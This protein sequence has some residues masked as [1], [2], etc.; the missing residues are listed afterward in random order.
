[1]FFICTAAAEASIEFA[2]EDSLTHY[3]NESGSIQETINAASPGDTIIVESGTYYENVDVNKTG[4]ILQGMDTDSGLPVVNGTGGDFC[5]KLSEDTCTL[6]GF[7][8]T[9]ADEVGVWVASSGNT[10]SDNIVCSETYGFYVD[11]SGYDFFEGYD[12]GLE[13][14][15]SDNTFTDNKVYNN[16][17]SDYD[18]YGIFLYK[19]GFNEFTGN[20]VSNDGNSD[21]D[22]Y[23]IYLYDD[24]N[25][26]VFT[27]NTLSNAGDSDEDCYGIYLYED[28]DS[29]VFT[30][31][32]VSNDGNSDAE[33]CGIYLD[34]Y[35][36]SN[37]FTGNMVSNYGNSDYD[38]YG[39]YLYYEC[40]SNVFT[41]NTLSND[42]DY[43]A[44]CCGIYLDDY[45]NS[46]KFTGN[47]V[48]N[49]GNSDYDCYGIYLYYEC[50]SNVFTD[51]TLSNDGD[52]DAE[53]CGIYLDDYCNSNEFT[54]NT[55]I[56]NGNSDSYCYGIILYDYCE[57]NTFSGNVICG[58]LTLPVYGGDSDNSWCISDQYCL[59]EA[60]YQ[61][62][63][64]T[65]E[66]LDWSNSNDDYCSESVSIGFDFTLDGMTYTRMEVVSNGVIH[67][68]PEGGVELDD[69]DYDYASQWAD[70]YPEETFIFALSDD[71]YAGD[72]GWY[73]YKSYLTGDTD[74]GGIAIPCN[75]TVID[76]HVSTY[77]DYGYSEYPNDFQ[78]VLYEDGTLRFNF[79]R[80]D[81]LSFDYSLDSGLY[82]GNDSSEHS[83][84]LMYVARA[85]D[86]ENETSFSTPISLVSSAHIGNYYGD[87][88][89][90]YSLTESAYQWFNTTRN[91]ATWNDTSDDDY[92]E[93]VPIGFN[94]T[95]DGVNY[96]HMQVVSNG[97]IQLISAGSG[98]LNDSSYDGHKYWVETYPDETFIFALCD[99]LS[100]EGSEEDLHQYTA[101]SEKHGV[102]STFVVNSEELET[103]NE[104][105]VTEKDKDKDKD[106]DKVKDVQ[107]TMESGPIET[108]LMESTFPDVQWY[109]YTRYLAGDND[110]EGNEIPVN[111]TVIDYHLATYEDSY[112]NGG[113]G[114]SPLEF[115]VL[116]YENGTIRF[117]FKRIEYSYFDA[118]LYSGLYL[119]NNSSVHAKELVHAA[120]AGQ[121]VNGISFGTPVIRTLSSSYDA[122]G[123]GIADSA[124]D[125]AS[126]DEDSEY[127]IASYISSISSSY[128]GDRQTDSYPLVLLSEANAPSKASSE[129]TVS[130]TVSTRFTNPA[131]VGVD[132]V[133]LYYR[134]DSGDWS[135]YGECSTGTFKFSTSEAGDY[136]FY[137]VATDVYGNVEGLPDDYDSHT[138]VSISSRSN[139]NGPSH[140]QPQPSEWEEKG[141]TFREP[142]DSA[143]VKFDKEPIYAIEVNSKNPFSNAR[144]RTKNHAGQ[145]SGVPQPEGTVYKYMDMEFVSGD[146]DIEG[147]SIFFKVDKAW[148][149]ENGLDAEDVKLLR[150]HDGEWV[151]LETTVE[152]EDAD[153]FY[154]SALTPGFSTFAIVAEGGSGTLDLEP[155]VNGEVPA[156][157]T[158]SEVEKPEENKEKSP[159]FGIFAGVIGLAVGFFM[160]RD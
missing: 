125:I 6:E 89:R 110:S 137:T 148:F 95:L 4:I 107:V 116:L 48:S 142:A 40:N 94:L 102:E 77:D 79:K 151:E 84:E 33:C 96:T 127:G 78:V 41:D 93:K 63:N 131:S 100:A 29:N 81:Y 21:Y 124:Y 71:L 17:D 139:S 105:A 154:F 69:D 16:G 149:E 35:C 159:G 22:C 39:I 104:K 10:V 34:D 103:L 136:Y 121:Y 45:C 146:C 92:S 111:L 42:G 9:G 147:A 59:N 66:D 1:M 130:F 128:S 26:N 62:I 56:N 18:C 51:N 132:M 13:Y 134:Q 80:I 138:A 135:K 156:E 52:Y 85:G 86:Y 30:G 109:G 12:S 144:F 113:Y 101:A 60:D 119:G 25:S 99:D 36:N 2:A 55:L 19:S 65:Q 32:M 129:G 58:N 53:C 120:R 83:K 57:M 155:S 68:I 3:V 115:Q 153:Y 7:N 31:N 74:S 97:V 70:W 140:Y 91:D 152:D 5:I 117:N 47:M 54:G 82:L 157:E 61:W 37:E 27:G 98:E 15:A 43:D 122:N 145:P 67:L 73:G 133:E 160:R 11:A 8:V 46:N 126:Y 112:Y 88:Y 118:S 158:A 20:M 72:D 106:K 14:N 38:C 141:V 23:G 76:Y 50:N 114:E 123:D 108:A 90:E 150:Y 44:E 49:Y 87:V 64:I 143:N 75:M 24:C 28:C